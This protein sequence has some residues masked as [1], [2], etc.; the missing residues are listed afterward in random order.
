MRAE[1][2]Q[3]SPKSRMQ[4]PIKPDASPNA[5]PQFAHLLSPKFKNIL[6]FALCG[7]RKIPM[8]H[9]RP[10][11]NVLLLPLFSPFC[12]HSG[13]SRCSCPAGVVPMLLA[14][15]DR[16]EGRNGSPLAHVAGGPDAPERTEAGPR[17][18]S[19][20]PTNKTRNTT[21]PAAPMVPECSRWRKAGP[22][23]HKD[24]GNATRKRAGADCIAGATRERGK[25]RSRAGDKPTSPQ[26]GVPPPIARSRKHL[27]SS[28]IRAKKSAKSR[29]G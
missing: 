7:Y 12:P 24:R 28:Q 21:G 5:S 19:P 26:K 23:A 11:K 13:L 22:Q 18:G 3:H 17:Q 27:P 15:Q 9:Q 14:N 20:A 10:S 16:E 1:A 8:K 2:L 29:L 25:K 6:V 4:A